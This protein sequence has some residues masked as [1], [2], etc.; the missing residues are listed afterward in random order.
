MC[1]EMSQRFY[2]HSEN[3]H[4]ERHALAEHLRWNF[5]SNGLVKVQEG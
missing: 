4:G 5:T 2:A 1:V 3:D